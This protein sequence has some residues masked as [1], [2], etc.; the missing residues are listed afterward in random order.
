MT[1]FPWTREF[2]P[3]LSSPMFTIIGDILLGVTL[4][5]RWILC[6]GVRW[7]GAASS[8]GNWRITR[9]RVVREVFKWPLKLITQLRLPRVVIC[10]KMS[11]QFFNQC[12]ATQLIAPCEFF[13]ALSQ[14][15]H[16]CL[17]FYLV[18]C[19]VC[20]DG[21]GQSNCF[22]INF[23]TVIWNC[24]KAWF[25][26]NRRRSQVIARSLKPLNR[27]SRRDWLQS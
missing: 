14:I 1:L 6:W 12:E 21:I 5:R 3:R 4:R 18:H 27:R 11:R 2:S 17:E 24:S 9:R 15:T 16:N 19:A 25:T 26:Y 20:F 7:G 13:R 23:L 8:Y 10:L 22:R